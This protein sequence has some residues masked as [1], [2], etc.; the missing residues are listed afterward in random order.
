MVP[1]L[2]AIMVLPL[3][4]S[5]ALAGIATG[6]LGGCRLL[7]ASPIGAITD[8]HGRRVGLVLGLLVRL[9]G[10]LALGWSMAGASF[11]AC[12]LGLGL[13]GLGVGAGQQ[14]RLAAAERSPPSR[15]AAGWGSVRMGSL[16]GAFGGPLLITLAEALSPRPRL[17]PLALS[18]RLVP[19]VLLPSLGVVRR[20]R[21][22]PNALAA[23]LPVCDPDDPGASPVRSDTGA[24]GS[25]RRL[26]RDH[27]Q[28]VAC[29]RSFALHGNRSMIMAM[30]S[31]AL[32]DA[33]DARPAV[34]FAVAIH[35]LGMFGL[36]L[37]LSHLADRLGRRHVMLGGTVAAGAGSVGVALS[38][39]Y[40]VV[41]AG[42]FLVGLGWSG[43]PIA[44]VALCAD[45]TPPPARG[46]LLG[47]NDALTATASIGL[48]L[49]A[50]PLVAVAGLEPLAVE[51]VGLLFVPL[52]LLLGLHESSP[53]TYGMPAAP[54]VGQREMTHGHA[55]PATPSCME[56]PSMSSPHLPHAHT[57]G[58]VDPTML[59][60]Q[61]G[62]WAIN[63][64]S[65][66]L[67]ATALIQTVIVW[68]SGSVAL[69]ADTIRTIGAAAT[70]LPLWMAFVLTRR[71]P[72]PRFTHGLG[73]AEDLAGVLIV[74]LILCSAIVVGYLSRSRLLNPQP[75]AHLGAVMAAA[76]I[77]FLGNEA[78]A[79]LRLKVGKDMG[80]AGLMA[81][82]DQARVDGWTIIAVLVG[83]IGTWFG[84]PIVDPI[85]GFV[86]TLAIV[87]IVWESGGAMF[88]RLLDGV[89]PTVL[90]EVKYAARHTPEVH[91]VT[92]VRVRWVGHRL[93]AERNIPVSAQLSVA[94]GHAIATAVR[95]QLLHHLPHLAT[96]MI[97]VDPLDASG[98]EHHRIVEHVHGDLPAHAHL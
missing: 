20:I 42:A 19:V 36:S 70:A 64:S 72:S 55:S 83:T 1:A 44:V 62:L 95:H 67:G 10:A 68:L 90:A 9:V 14:L 31:L 32:T 61:R 33:G 88:T 15:R 86:I 58:S 21:P 17:D 24:Q 22:D 56:G 2:G 7:V 73:R 53:G 78:V 13:F 5:P 52:F 75:T 51:R 80:S 27:P 18:W 25:V 60:T 54:A 94:Q 46:R 23:N 66:G 49:L 65:V 39:A 69:L 47:V 34:S 4:G 28:R 3:Q 45:T 82:G 84:Y 59:T 81:D 87:R 26:L 8:R 93:H 37:P 57:H 74:G 11:P 77:G 98:E 79:L 48:P 97:H 35:V 40:W 16:V 38:S 43:R 89:E 6:I 12:L 92:Q 91:E 63:W 29:I 96:A 71:P 85:V 30:T 50:G 76:L 41:P